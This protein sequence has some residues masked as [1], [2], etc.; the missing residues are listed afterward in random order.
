[1]AYSQ[2]VVIAGGVAHVPIIIGLLK[3]LERRLKAQFKG[4]KA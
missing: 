3:V 4:A 2:T 1:M